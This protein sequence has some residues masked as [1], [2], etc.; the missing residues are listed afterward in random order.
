MRLAAAPP[1]VAEA[2]AEPGDQLQP[3]GPSAD[4]DNAVQVISQAWL[5]GPG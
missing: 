2:V 3:A 5:L 1:P 4:D